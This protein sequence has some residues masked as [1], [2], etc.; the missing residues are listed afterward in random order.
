LTAEKKNSSRFSSDCQ[1]CWIF[2]TANSFC[3]PFTF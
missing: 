3:F 1:S 2:S